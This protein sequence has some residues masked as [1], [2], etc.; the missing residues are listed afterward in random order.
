MAKAKAKVVI[1]GTGKIGT[2]LAERILK[3][4]ELDLIAFIGRRKNSDNLIRFRNRI[5][6]LVD[7]GFE[8]FLSLN[9][10]FDFGTKSSTSLEVVKR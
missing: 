10:E 1:I 7:G 5:P 8:E 9:I 4:N 3:S 6:N 2:D